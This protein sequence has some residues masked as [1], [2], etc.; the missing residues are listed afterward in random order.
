MITIIIA[1]SFK[2]GSKAAG[3]CGLVSFGKKQNLFQQQRKAIK[4]I[5]PKSKIIYVY[6]FDHKK[7]ST[8]IKKN[9]I[10]SDTQPV[11]NSLYS[12]HSEGYSLSLALKEITTDEDCLV[13]FGYEPVDKDHLKHIKN[14]KHSI[15][16]I[17]RDNRTNLGCILDNNS[18]KIN[19]IF[20]G[21]DNYI[22]NTYFLKKNEIKILREVIKHNSIHNMFL[23][24]IINS[25]ISRNG[26]LF[27]MV[28]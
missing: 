5:F 24:E 15:A 1:D 17:N 18:K 10:E 11:F 26:T 28:I 23:F 21:L 7:F 6:G 25:I 3:C 9:P 27:P 16:F 14:T 20:F 8:F 2:K 12:K 19:H 13:L 22:A 4:S